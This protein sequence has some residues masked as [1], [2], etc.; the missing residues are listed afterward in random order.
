MPAETPPIPHVLK[1][2]RIPLLLGLGMMTM[3]SGLGNPGCGSQTDSDSSPTCVSGCAIE[4]TYRLQFEDT[5]TLPA[6]CMALGLTLPN[7]P[8]VLTFANTLVEATLEGD[9]LSG[10]YYGEPGLRF[11]LSGSRDISE[12]IG[13]LLEMTAS[14]SPAPQTATTPVTLQGTFKL[15]TFSSE[16]NSPGCAYTRRYTAT[17]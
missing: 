9:E 16:S 7:G 5:S 14:V 1:P 11:S 13:S 10:A 4:G 3:G 15:T 12:K 2:L 17:R 6:D 8:L